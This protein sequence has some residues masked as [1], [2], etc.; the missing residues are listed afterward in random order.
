M[1]RKERL[2]KTNKNKKRKTVIKKHIRSQYRVQRK[3]TRK[4]I[5]IT[6]ICFLI[7]AIIYTLNYSIF[8]YNLFVRKYHT[9]THQMVNIEGENGFDVKVNHYQK[10]DN[11]IEQSV[12]GILN[13]Y[14]ISDLPA[15]ER[16]KFLKNN[17][18][19]EAVSILKIID[20][21]LTENNFLHR[22]AFLLKATLTGSQ[23]DNDIKTIIRD[24]GHLITSR[25][26][27]SKIDI[28]AYLENIQ[29]ETAIKTFLKGNSD[30]IA[31]IAEHIDEDYYLTDCYNTTAIYLGIGE[32]LGLPIK[33]V[34]IPNHSFIRWK[35]GDDKYI[36]WEVTRGILSNDYSYF[37]LSGI[38]VDDPVVKNGVY[39]RELER[40]ENF[41]IRYILLGNLILELGRNANNL[42]SKLAYYHKAL[43]HFQKAL[44]YNPKFKVVFNNIGI[45]YEKLGDVALKK[46][47][48]KNAIELYN[49]AIE[50]Y[51]KAYA[52]FPGN[53]M[54]LK[55]KNN[56]VAKTNKL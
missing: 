31:Y 27:F 52:A 49:N 23:I 2:K 36:D 43:E 46:Q 42:K 9:I 11:V 40:N 32:V 1:G 48:K 5:G 28:S 34:S 29:R 6:S 45:A 13:F 26:S 18:K 12:D 10:L 7:L 50:S 54:F 30:K 33:S 41:G 15:T 3:N 47:N 56:L 55:Q 4:I 8:G 19:E 22:H 53:S 16:N 35:F 14:G 17:K 51:D 37:Q 38:N 39:F 25:D 24:K 20:K 21:T 44:G